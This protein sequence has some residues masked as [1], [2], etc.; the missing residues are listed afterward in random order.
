MTFVFLILLTLISIYTV[1]ADIPDNVFDSGIYEVME[2]IGDDHLIDVTFS[3]ADG[4]TSCFGYTVS[5]DS[6]DFWVLTIDYSGIPIDREELCIRENNPVDWISG[7][8]L[9]SGLLLIIEGGHTPGS[10]PD[11]F[12]IDLLNPDNNRDTVLPVEISPDEI[13]TLLSLEKCSEGRL[14]AA[15]TR[16]TPEDGHTLFVIKLGYD[17]TILWE[18][19]LVENSE[20]QFT[21]ASLESMSDGGCLLSFDLDCFQSSSIPICRLG[22]DGQILWHKPLQVDCEFIAGLSGFLELNDGSI[23]CTGTVDDMR[24]MAF[25]GFTACLDSSGEELW[26]RIDWY[27]DHT[28]FLSARI[29]PQDHFLITGW[30]G[31]EGDFSLE[32]VDTDVLLVIMSNDGSRIIGTELSAEGDQKTHSV[33]LTE[34]GQIIVTGTEIQPG[35]EEADIFLWRL[36]FEGLL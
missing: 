25:R 26:R 6:T 9:E 24:H 21:R 32:L 12:A 19:P 5:G 8:F 15:G 3:E 29:T 14:L 33:F 13:L 17:G 1:L 4:V 16:W 30:T 35:K 34:S 28:S 2:Y 27:L 23:L 36:G 22:S 7:V 11:I 10:F 18:T 20:K 31:E